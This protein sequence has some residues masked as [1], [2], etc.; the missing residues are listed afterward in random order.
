MKAHW[1]Y[2]KYVLRHKW[3]VFLWC[4]HYHIPFA[5]LVHDLSKFHPREWF[6]YVGKFYGGDPERSYGGNRYPEKHYGDARLVFDDKWTQGW[7]DARFDEA[8]NHHQKRNPHHWQ[9]WVLM[10]DSGK[11][12][13]L[14]VPLRYRKEM[15]ADW[16]GASIAITGKD[17]TREWYK[18]NRHKMQLHP[19][20]R[21]WVEWQLGWWATMNGEPFSILDLADSL[22][23]EKAQ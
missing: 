20:T 5:G 22:Q 11:V 14:D 10:E 17:N 18:A 15:L 12:T 13:P 1:Q 4:C 2:L 8:W 3:H 23:K 9:Y 19:D 7:V 6:P 21:T 16:R